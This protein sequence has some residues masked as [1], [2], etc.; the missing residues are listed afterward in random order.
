MIS[1]LFL[2]SCPLLWHQK[3]R[4]P[5]SCMCG[6]RIWHRAAGSE[7]LLGQAQKTQALST[8]CRHADSVGPQRLENLHCN[9]L[10]GTAA[11]HILSSSG[12]K[13]CPAE[14]SHQCSPGTPSQLCWAGRFKG[15]KRVQA[16]LPRLQVALPRAW[17]SEVTGLDTRNVAQVPQSPQRQ[18]GPKNR[19]Q[20]GCLSGILSLLAPCFRFPPAVRHWLSCSPDPVRLMHFR[21]IH[22]VSH[23]GPPWL[24]VIVSRGLTCTLTA[25]PEIKT[26]ATPIVQ[27]SS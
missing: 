10:S 21:R 22:T 4:Q 12:L 18:P 9:K 5:E 27:V 23:P 2:F 15:Q 14:K 19:A 13:P 1:C 25:T 6:M 3:R 16:A 20:W 17:L 7:D 11:D 24:Q 26:M 8:T